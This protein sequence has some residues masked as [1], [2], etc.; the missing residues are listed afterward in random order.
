MLPKHDIRNDSEKHK[1]SGKSIA[2][3]A[4]SWGFSDYMQVKELL[5][6]W[7]TETKLFFVVQKSK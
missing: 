3:P 2:L 4:A 6:G 7:K 1:Q 5:D